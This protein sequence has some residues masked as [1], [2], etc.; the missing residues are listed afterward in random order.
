MQFPAALLGFNLDLSFPPIVMLPPNKKKKET[1]KRKNRDDENREEG[2][3]NENDNDNVKSNET[4]QEQHYLNVF[5]TSYFY[6][7]F[8]TTPHTI[9]CL[10]LKKELMRQ[11][12]FT[13]YKWRTFVFIYANEDSCTD[14]W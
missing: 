11:K 6:Q 5:D 3:V 12:H 14:N 7:L 8:F 13:A 9:R 10:N 1:E 2:N 4:L